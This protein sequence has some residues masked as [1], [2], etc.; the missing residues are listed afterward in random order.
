M[1][2]Y[3]TGFENGDLLV[4][5]GGAQGVVG[6]VDIVAKVHALVVGEGLEVGDLIAYDIQGVQTGEVAKYIDVLNAIFI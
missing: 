2:G 6:D 4:D 5:C 1:N 3:A